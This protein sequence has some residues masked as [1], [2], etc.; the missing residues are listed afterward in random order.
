M[1]VSKVPESLAVPT[2]QTQ[3]V[4]F[5]PNGLSNGLISVEPLLRSE[6]QPTYAQELE[7][8][9]NAGFYGNMI[10]CLGTVAGTLGSIP[11]CF[12]CPNPYKPVQQGFVGLVSRYGQ[13]YK[14]VDPGLVKINPFAE[15]LRTIS[16]QIQ[17]ALVPQQVALTRDNVSVQID[18]VIY[19]HVK[20]PYKAAF[21]IQDVRTALIERA[22]STLRQVVGARTLQNL[23]TERDE[24]A[25]EIEEIV[26]KV[27]E[28]WG[29]QIESL[30]IKDVLFSPELQQSLSSAAQQ[31]RIGEAKVIAARAEVDSAV[32]M[33]QAADIL[34]SDAAMQIRQLEAL[35]AMAKSGNS[36]IIFVPMP[37]HGMNG[38]LQFGGDESKQIAGSSN[39]GPMN[40]AT[41][42]SNINNLA[43]M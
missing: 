32:L 7:I 31:K 30:L 9:S 39:A 16:V 25:R 17:L 10:G 18:S 23:I 13:F 41:Y 33:R 11:L 3:G 28:I 21:G 26:E 20:N 12:C 35:Q 8:T 27:V 19:W 42:A 5:K 2:S 22:Q 37:L 14:S 36:K 6:M 4:P 1:S 15:E 24:I 29:I 40:A 38:G 34:A 43:N